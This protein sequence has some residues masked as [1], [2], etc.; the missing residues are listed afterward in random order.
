MT[1]SSSAR[2][3]PLNRNDGPNTEPTGLGSAAGLISAGL[4]SAGLSSPAGSTP[5]RAAGVLAGGDFKANSASRGSGKLSRD[6][7]LSK[8]VLLMDALS[9]AVF[10]N[11]AMGYSGRNQAA[12]GARCPDPDAGVFTVLPSL[13]STLP[14]NFAPCRMVTDGAVM[15]PVMSAVSVTATDL[16]ARTSPSI[17]PSMTTMVAL[18]GTI[19]G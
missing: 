5:A 18:E 10:L 13:M 7:R 1:K 6:A 2:N 14:L 11:Q 3:S 12:F 16:S 15:L 9:P 8:F 4:T 17:V 19:E